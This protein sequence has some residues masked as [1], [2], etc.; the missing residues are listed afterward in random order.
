MKQNY[1]K[2]KLEIL[3]V[4]SESRDN[5][6]NVVAE[7]PVRIITESKKGRGAAYNTGFEEARSDYVAY[8]DSDAVAQADWLKNAL[9]ILGQDSSIAVV[10]F[11]SLAPVDSSYFQ[12]CVDT[13]LSKSW[14]QANAAV[15]RKTAL[16]KVGGFNRSLPYLQ[17]DE[18]KI[19]LLKQGYKIQ[20]A[21]KPIIQHYPRQDFKSYLI[22]CIESGIGS[23][24]LFLILKKPYLLMKLLTRALVAIIPIVTTTLF[25]LY[26][27]YAWILGL[28]TIVGLLLYATHLWRSTDPRY[29]LVK[30]VLPATFL[31]WLSTLTGL[32]GYVISLSE[33]LK[34]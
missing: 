1:P 32:L 14:G 9:Q 30:Y 21:H 5:T 6:L 20:L 13:L 7:Y 10:H 15:Y 2:D 27:P 28:G 31:M 18:V 4:D 34:K 17:E 19:K 12:K 8:L 16:E 33:S 29:R 23:L 3:I 11:K 26:W 24:K 22:Q 25:T